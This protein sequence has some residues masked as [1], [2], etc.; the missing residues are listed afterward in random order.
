MLNIFYST[1]PERLKCWRQGFGDFPHGPLEVWPSCS[2]ACCSLVL[3][4]TPT[5][6]FALCHCHLLSY[7]G[8][9]RFVLLR[10]SHRRM[11]RSA[12]VDGG[13]KF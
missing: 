6:L 13:F 10:W 8:R 1:A 5:A 7:T 2:S 4:L 11:P 12:F 3:R 9:E